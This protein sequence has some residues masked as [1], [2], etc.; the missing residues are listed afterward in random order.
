MVEF[1]PPK[2]K[3][4]GESELHRVIASLG[5]SA[6]ALEKAQ[7]IIANQAMLRQRD[8][9]AL[10]TWIK[11]MQQDGSAAAQAALRK[12]VLDTVPVELPKPLPDLASAPLSTNFQEALFTSELSLIKR[13]ELSQ[14]A[15]L[16]R[17]VIPSLASWIMVGLVNCIIAVWLK[18]NDLEALIS[19][20]IGVTAAGL[21]L[22]VLKTHT[23]HPLTRSAAVFG[24][25]GVYL[26]AALAIALSTLI[27]LEGTEATSDFVP[28]EEFLGYDNR[29]LGM[30]AIA[31][32]VAQLV[33]REIQF[34]VLAAGGIGVL[35]FGAQENG[36]FS[37]ISVGSLV[38]QGS[39]DLL[40]FDQVIWGSLAVAFSTVTLF[41]FSMPHVQ[42]RAW[43]FSLQI[44]LGIGV[45][46]LA[47]T[48]QG[49]EWVTLLTLGLMMLSASFSGRDLAAGWLGR[50]AGLAFLIPVVLMPLRDFVAGPAVSLVIVLVTLLF[51]D[52]LVRRSALHIPSLDTSYGFYGAFHWPTWLA[53]AISIPLG[54][55]AVQRLLV[56]NSEFSETELALI[57][58]LVVGIVFALIRIPFIRAQDTEI[59]NVEFRNLNLDNL[60]GL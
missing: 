51:G 17:N 58:G 16:L 59:K 37:P 52:Q 24:G 47:L 32:M 26:G 45:S 14:R 2:P 53:L 34:W 15:Q 40:Q 8:A 35:V 54:T 3:A 29:V 25:W 57:F 10:A 55:E 31:L 41:A 56:P 48:I 1:E 28:I 23:L 46:V 33:G 22:L 30:A 39:W 4:L 5:T 6:E 21:I 11:S 44:P 49:V 9:D 18:L 50:L 60:L 7:Q 43:S 19:F 36:G 27:V 12:I 20:A 13:R 38:S 42:T